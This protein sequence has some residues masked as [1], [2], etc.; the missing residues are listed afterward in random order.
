[1]ASTLSLRRSFVADHFHDLPGFQEDRHGH[2]WEV[3][4]AVELASEAGEAAFAKV[5]DAWVAG[6][7]YRLLNDLPG[8]AGRNPTAELLAEQAFLYLRNAALEP[9]WVRIREKANYWALCRSEAAS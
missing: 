5:L 8:L 4:A 7:D 3:E 6:I 2:N 9:C 1:M